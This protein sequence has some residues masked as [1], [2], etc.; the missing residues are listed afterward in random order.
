MSTT[1]HFIQHRSEHYHL[2]RLY[3][4]SSIYILDL[5]QSP[6]KLLFL[7]YKKYMPSIAA[8]IFTA[9]VCCSLLPLSEQQYTPDWTSI[10]S[11]PL[12][13]W[14]DE[15]KVGIFIHW[16]VFS[17]PSFS[18]EWSVS[19]KNQTNPPKICIGFGNDG[20]EIHQLQQLWNL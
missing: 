1:I 10:D 8:V 18:S 16:G 19:V 13:A 9:V 4:I 6:S 20:K 17:V 5:C 11:R 2:L 3:L 7:D 12:P 15:S 14:Y